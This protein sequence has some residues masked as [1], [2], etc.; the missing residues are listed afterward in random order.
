MKYDRM[1][2][3]GEKVLLVA[4]D[5]DCEN[6]RE[7]S[8]V[9][10]MWFFH[11]RHSN[12]GDKKDV[13]AEDFDG[14]E[15]MAEHLRT[16]EGALHIA[17]VFMY[18]HSGR[19]LSLGAF[20][21]RWDSGQLGLMWTTKEKLA[22]TVGENATDEQIMKAY[23]TELEE[24]NRW[25]EGDCWWYRLV[26]PPPGFDPD[27]AGMSVD[28]DKWTEKDT[29]GG[30]LG[31]DDKESGLLDNAFGAEAKNAVEVKVPSRDHW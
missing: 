11:G 4:H 20:G 23:A 19:S 24:Y 25:I 30:F 1:Y 26:S 29:C 16:E 17:P 12:L 15:E 3:L 6:P 22:E 8:N 9:S 28:Y 14:W 27:A 21:D 5:E 2:T 7:H 18:E 10:V 13:K 31:Y